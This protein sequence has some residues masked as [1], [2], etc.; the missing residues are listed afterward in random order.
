VRAARPARRRRS[1]WAWAPAAA[2]HDRRDRRGRRRR[3]QAAAEGALR[4]LGQARPQD[5]QRHVLAQDRDVIV[6]TTS[7]ASVRGAREARGEELVPLGPRQMQGQHVRRRV[8]QQSSG[9]ATPSSSARARDVAKNARGPDSV[10]VPVTSPASG[11]PG[12]LGGGGDALPQHVVREVTRHHVGRH[13]LE[14]AL[15]VIAPAASDAASTFDSSSGGRLVA[16]TSGVAWRSTSA[17]RE[18]LLGEARLHHR[19]EPA[20][21]RFDRHRG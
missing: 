15:G 13:G 1:G 2:R 8:D 7:R 10:E 12:A 3:D 9:V 17:G 14:D 21:T 19:R 18:D 6:S 5:R 20:L 4:E 11:D 16:S